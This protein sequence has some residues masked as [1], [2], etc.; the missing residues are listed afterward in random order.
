ME[1][2]IHKQSMREPIDVFV[3]NNEK[4]LNEL[5]PNYQSKGI[6]FHR[7]VDFSV[8]FP[9]L[10]CLTFFGGIGTIWHCIDNYLPMLIVP[11]MVGDQLYNGGIVLERGLG[12]C[13]PMIENN[14]DKLSPL[15]A[16]L[17]DASGYREKITTLRSIHDYSDTMETVCERLEKL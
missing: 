1:C 5:L 4:L 14:C 10:K 12:E 2:L 7:W 16:R 9:E 8:H 11:G 17:G 3:G 15:L 13:F 6:R